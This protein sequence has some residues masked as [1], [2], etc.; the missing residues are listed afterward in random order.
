MYLI[1]KNEPGFIVL[2]AFERQGVAPLLCQGFPGDVHR[3]FEALRF[4]AKFIQFSHY[5]RGG[6]MLARSISPGDPLFASGNTLS[7]NLAKTLTGS[8]FVE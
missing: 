6:N 5:G 4:H 8:D 2:R 7:G 1:D 3:K